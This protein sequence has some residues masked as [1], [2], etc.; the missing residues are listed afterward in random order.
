MGNNRNK[1]EEMTKNMM[2]PFFLS[3]DRTFKKKSIMNFK[4]FRA[5]CATF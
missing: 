2:H 3:I 1:S 4:K 5:I